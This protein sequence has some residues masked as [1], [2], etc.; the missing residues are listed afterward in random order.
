[1][2]DNRF[3]EHRSRLASTESETAVNDCLAAVELS[4]EILDLDSENSQK[5]DFYW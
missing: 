5:V 2:R 3:G 4:V 1:M